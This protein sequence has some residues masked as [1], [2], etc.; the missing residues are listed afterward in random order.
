MGTV[1]LDAQPRHDPGDALAAE[2]AHQFV[3]QAQ[4]KAAGAWVAETPGAPAQLVVDA[5]RFVAF[6]ADD[7]QPAQLTHRLFAAI[8]GTPLAR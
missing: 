3:F 1:V 2:F 7:V 4:I 6:G 5:P 8:V